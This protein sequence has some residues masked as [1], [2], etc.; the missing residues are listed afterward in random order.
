MEDSSRD[1]VR[2][3]GQFIN[4]PI[5]ASICGLE[6]ALAALKEM[7]KF[8][9]AGFADPNGAPLETPGSSPIAPTPAAGGHAGDATPATDLVRD[10]FHGL[11]AF[12][13]PGSDIYSSAQGVVAPE[14]GAVSVHV[15]EILIG[16]LD[17]AVPS[18]PQG[19]ASS[20]AIASLLNQVAQKVNPSA[21]GAFPSFFSRLSFRDKVAVF[22][23]L[24]GDPSMAPFKR[25]GGLLAFFVAFLFYSE[26]ST[27]DFATRALKGRPAGWIAS[28]YEGVSDGRC[29]FKGYYQNRKQAE[30]RSGLYAGMERKQG[31]VM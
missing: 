2:V 23:F 17:R 19:P 5:S 30:K 3:I 24:E 21:S 1:V 9:N 31:C 22:Q 11:A 25:I 28:R 18:P 4:L 7:Q 15:A 26:A 14:P 20:A 6:F 29:E 27:F 13:V 16:V 10:T 12:V 8:L